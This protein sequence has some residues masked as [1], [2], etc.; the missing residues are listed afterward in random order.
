MFLKDMSN[1]SE[2]RNETWSQNYP[3]K[4]RE[5]IE[6]RGKEQRTTV[7]VETPKM[8]GYMGTWVLLR[9]YIV[10]VQDSLN[11]DTLDSNSM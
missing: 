5:G 9:T 6:R 3:F 7:H 4:T 10:K 1:M 2:N 8:V 11:I